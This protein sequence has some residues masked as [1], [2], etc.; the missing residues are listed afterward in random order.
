MFFQRLFA[1]FEGDET[2]YDSC[3]LQFI[4]FHSYFDRSALGAQG[5]PCR[6]KAFLALKFIV[7]LRKLAKKNGRDINPFRFI[8][9]IRLIPFVESRDYFTYSR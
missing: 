6:Q 5:H 3:L 2:E 4:D 7:I 8:E 9:I 1:F